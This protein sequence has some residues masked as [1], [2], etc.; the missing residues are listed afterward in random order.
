ML[1]VFLKLSMISVLLVACLDEL[2]DAIEIEAAIDN[3]L[4]NQEI[5]LIFQRNGIIGA[6]ASAAAKQP[7]KV[8]ENLQ[9]IIKTIDLIK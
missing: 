9:M 1:R 2:N 3:G 5:Q 6:E 8:R 4:A 7:L